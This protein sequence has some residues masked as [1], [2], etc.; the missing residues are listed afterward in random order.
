MYKVCSSCG[1][2][3]AAKRDTANYC[4]NG[5][6]Q[7]A[8]RKRNG[9]Q[10]PSFLVNQPKKSKTYSQSLE[11]GFLGALS[12]SEFEQKKR[13]K[14]RELNEHRTKLINDRDYFVRQR[15]NLFTNPNGSSTIMGSILGA[16]IAGAFVDDP[17][18]IRRPKAQPGKSF[19]TRYK[20]D[21]NEGFKRF[22]GAAIGAGAGFYL[23]NSVND[24]QT[25]QKQALHINVQLTKLESAIKIAEKAIHEVESQQEPIQAHREPLIFPPKPDPILAK[26]TNDDSL[27]QQTSSI[28]SSLGSTSSMS[29]N[30]LMNMKFPTLQFNEKYR[31]LV[32]NPSMGF[33]MI[34]YGLPKQGKST[35]CFEFA[36]YLADT[37][38]KTVYFLAEEGFGQ[39]VK[40]KLSRQTKLSTYLFFDATRDINQF[41]KIIKSNHYRYVVIDSVNHLGMTFQQ[42]EELKNSNPE[43]TFICVLQSTKGGDFKG[44]QEFAH[45]TDVMVK[46]DGGVAYANGRFNAQGTLQLF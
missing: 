17:K 13:Q 5:C 44:G 34:V 7:E 4:S 38:G 1:K 21:E 8:Y 26:K 6:K 42:I 23:S 10:S 28:K 19:L 18:P 39:T 31:S 9:I 3:F 36:N 24:P 15:D 41:D 16:F 2:G 11:E 12:I 46:V 33:S 40:E 22:V 37:H 35:F 14:L 32:G 20:K 25:I 29:A 30:D 45:N 27:Y 43:V